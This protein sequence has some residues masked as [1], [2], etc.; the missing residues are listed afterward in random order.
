MELRAEALVN[1][2]SNEFCRELG[3]DE[4]S[5]QLSRATDMASFPLRDS[6]DCILRAALRES[7]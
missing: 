7:V 1:W 6:G 2:G 3:I 5:L 4:A